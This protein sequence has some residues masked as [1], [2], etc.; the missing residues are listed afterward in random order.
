M[1][2]KITVKSASPA[3]FQIIKNL[4]LTGLKEDPKAFS[5]DFEDYNKNSI[6]W[7]NSY[8]SP[9]VFSLK[10]KMLLAFEGD[11]PVGMI[12]ILYDY[13]SRRTH[14]ATI[15][16]FYISNN[17]RGLGIGK[18]LLNKAIEDAKSQKMKKITLFVNSQQEKAINMY[19]KYGFTANG[20]LEKELLIGNEYV[21]TLIFEMLFD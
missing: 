11:T 18:E 1:D 17:Y 6:E 20:K 12:G 21:D 9:Y 19:K 3:D 13:R 2:N 14:I 15:V 8:I 10:D 5:V 7:W 16:W 4:M